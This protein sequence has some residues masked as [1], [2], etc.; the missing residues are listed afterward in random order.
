MP[1]SRTPRPTQEAVCG[2]GADFGER[3]LLEVEPP[4]IDVIWPLLEASLRLCTATFRG[5]AAWPTSGYLPEQITE[6]PNRQ[7][8]EHE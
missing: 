4:F 5:W 6:R 2:H 7:L 8:A 3:P 1:A